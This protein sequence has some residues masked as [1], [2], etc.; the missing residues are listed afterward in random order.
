[1]GCEAAGDTGALEEW[2]SH[3]WEEWVEDRSRAMTAAEMRAHL[4]NAYDVPTSRVTV[5]VVA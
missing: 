4:A 3:G 2:E 1:M 5:E